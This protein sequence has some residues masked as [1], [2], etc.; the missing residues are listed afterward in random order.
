VFTAAT[1]ACQAVDVADN[2]R[3]HSVPESTSC[4]ALGGQPI[5]PA[6]QTSYAICS[7]VGGGCDDGASCV[8]GQEFGALTCIHRTG[9]LACPPG[10]YSERHLVVSTYQDDRTCGACS[11]A[12]DVQPT[13]V[14]EAF[15]VFT[16]SCGTMPDAIVTATC[17]GPVSG[18]HVRPTLAKS[19]GGTCMLTSPVD[20]FASG[21]VVPGEPEVLCCLP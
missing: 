20:S 16:G 11:C 10:D 7:G 12:V 8:R 13:C 17:G 6:F 21:A 19:Q 14:G 4:D 3:A 18:D 1:T 9:D 2:C 5:H 15:D